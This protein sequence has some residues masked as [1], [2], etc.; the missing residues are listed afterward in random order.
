MISRA[1]RVG[2]NLH[3]DASLLG[4]TTQA[5]VCKRVHSEYFKEL[6]TR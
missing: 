6:P 2:G 4:H 1:A 5:G 3:S